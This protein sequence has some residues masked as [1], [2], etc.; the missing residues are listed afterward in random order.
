MARRSV[1]DTRNTLAPGWPAAGLYI[2]DLHAIVVAEGAAS[3][4]GGRDFP[5]GTV[6]RVLRV[7]MVEH[8]LCARAYADL[9]PDASDNSGIWDVPLEHLQPLPSSP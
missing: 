8:Q 1:F 6:L 2:R 9:G 7:E 3:R 5:V 4:Y